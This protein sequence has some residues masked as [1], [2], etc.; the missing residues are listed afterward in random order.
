MGGQRNAREDEHE[1]EEKVYAQG[2]GMH[3]DV[4]VCGG[5]VRVR[6]AVGLSAAGCGSQLS[7]GAQGRGQARPG[8]SKA[9]GRQG[10]EPGLTHSK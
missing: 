2:L 3:C 7:G 6:Q 1:R 9:S 5:P 10:L 8:E 4:F